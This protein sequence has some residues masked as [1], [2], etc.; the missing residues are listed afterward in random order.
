MSITLELT[1]ELE[2]L[3]KAKAE[4]R[5]IPLEEYLPHLVAQAIQQEEWDEE[6]ASKAT[7]MGSLST[8]HRI[9]DTPEEDAAWK[10]LEDE[11][12]G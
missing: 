10:Y 5:G 1:A 6:D 8:M 3:A 2:H 4:A 7:I 12:N 11:E 9:W